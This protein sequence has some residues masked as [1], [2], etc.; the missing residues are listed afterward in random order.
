MVLARNTRNR[1]L[2]WVAKQYLSLGSTVSFV[3]PPEH[4]LGSPTSWLNDCAE[5]IYIKQC[6]SHDECML[7]PLVDDCASAL[8]SG[9]RG[10]A[11][12]FECG[13]GK[14]AN[15]RLVVASD[16]ILHEQDGIRTLDHKLVL[17]IAKSMIRV[18]DEISCECAMMSSFNASGSAPKTVFAPAGITH[19]SSGTGQVSVH[20]LD[21]PTVR[22]HI[23]GP[24]PPLSITSHKT[25]KT[26]KLN[27]RSLVTI[28]TRLPTRPTPN[29][30]DTMAKLGK[31]MMAPDK[32]F[33]FP[34]LPTPKNQVSGSDKHCRT[35]A[36]QFVV[37]AVHLS[38]SPSVHDVINGK[39][40]H[41]LDAKTALIPFPDF[42]GE[43]WSTQNSDSTQRS[44]STEEPL[45]VVD[46]TLDDYA[47][48]F[49]HFELPPPTIC[50]QHCMAFI[51]AG[52]RT[53]VLH[54]LVPTI[55]IVL[56]GDIKFAWTTSA[57]YDDGPI[58]ARHSKVAELV[59]VTCDR[60]FHFVLHGR[61]GMCLYVRS[62]TIL[63]IK[64]N[65]ASILL[66]V[67]QK[68]SAQGI[69][70]KKHDKV[71]GMLLV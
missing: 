4:V 45:L 3:C 21:K 20:Q 39:R 25:D 70:I 26:A 32:W 17:G 9:S 2:C 8:S 23:K 61:P 67:A 7:K 12:L 64:A 14:D 66:A 24:K 15:V 27:A 58:K 18:M 31:S 68:E 48:F 38:T 40:P 65:D 50:V 30:K 10:V 6:T 34:P 54:F 69:C 41:T 47:K 60:D 16:H 11:G 42:G 37:N 5:G 53:E 55:I 56:S 29:V 51:P 44:K 22:V 33:N 36:L 43:L 13:R 57:Q 71:K 49:E 59:H 1:G 19:D 28:A 35:R 52:R 62:G 46:G 63:Q